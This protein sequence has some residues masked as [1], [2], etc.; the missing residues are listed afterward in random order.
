M[1]SAEGHAFSW[2][3]VNAYGV[4]G[5]VT[6][7]VEVFGWVQANPN[8][9]HRA[10]AASTSQILARGGRMLRNG[11]IQ[12]GNWLE[13]HVTDSAFAR[14][15]DPISFTLLDLEDGT[16]LED[17][18]LDIDTTVGKEDLALP[19][20]IDDALLWAEGL[21]TI[22]ARY[23]TLL[24]DISSPYTVQQ[25]TARLT[26]D[27]GLVVESADTGMFDGLLPAVGT[28]AS[29][30]SFA[31]PT[32][33]TLDYNFGDFNGHELDI[34]LGL[35]NGGNALAEEVP[36]P[37]TLLLLVVGAGVLRRRCWGGRSPVAVR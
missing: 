12:W 13:D 28:P 18:L 26:I 24:V 5:P 34:S 8:I 32:E 6:G 22:T 33:F 2:A 37:A 23:A 31:F 29:D 36:E 1:S 17:T 16:Y 4:G 3:D 10:Y 35:G 19:G 30:L 11:R 15:K 14:G 9:V 21:I 25:G 27:E 20:G 7:E